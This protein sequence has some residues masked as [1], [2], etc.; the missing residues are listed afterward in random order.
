MKYI[1]PSVLAADFGNLQRDIEM[2]NDSQCDW[3][4]CDVMDGNFV[5]NISFGTP[6]L[7]AIQKVAKKTMDVHLMIEGPDRYVNLF[8]DCGAEVLSVHYENNNHLD[9]LMHQIRD[10]GMKSGL[11]LNPG[12]PPE[13]ISE[14]TDLIDVVVVMSV[15][16]GFGGQKFIEN[17][18]SKVIRLDAIRKNSRANFL[19]EID[20]GVSQHNAEKLFEAGADVLV[21]GSAVFRAEDPKAMISTLKAFGN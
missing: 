1:A 20:G 9:R 19:I 17:T 8:R 21:A 16:P 11:A 7:K 6:V 5:P 12:T 18:Y 10:A 15:N 13:V 3:I 4:H 14:L 2:L